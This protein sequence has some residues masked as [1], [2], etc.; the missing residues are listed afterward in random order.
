[1]YAGFIRNQQMLDEG[2]PDAILACWDGRSRGTLDMMN[3]A[4]RAKVP[5]GWL[6]ENGELSKWYV[7]DRAVV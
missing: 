1:M 4:R 5:V 6:R 3:R 7:P 2:K